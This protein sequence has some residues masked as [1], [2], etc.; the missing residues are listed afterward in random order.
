MSLWTHKTSDPDGSQV[1]GSMQLHYFVWMSAAVCAFAHTETHFRWVV[2]RV[3]IRAVR[4]YAHRYCMTQVQVQRETEGERNMTEVKR[5]E[6]SLGCEQEQPL[7][8]E[9]VP[10]GRQRGEEEEALVQVQ[11]ASQHWY[12]NNT[13]GFVCASVC[14]Y[15]VCAW[16]RERESYLVDG[17]VWLPCARGRMELRG[18]DWLC[19]LIGC[20]Q[21]VNDCSCL[22]RC[23]VLGT[24]SEEGWGVWDCVCGGE[25]IGA[26]ER[27]QERKRERGGRR[28]EREKENRSLWRE[29]GRELQAARLDY[30]SNTAV[31][32]L[33]LWGS[34]LSLLA[35]CLSFLLLLLL[36]LG[37]DPGGHLDL[38][39]H[40]EKRR[41]N[42]VAE[43]GD[44]RRGQPHTLLLW[45]ESGN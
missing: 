27:R 34:C 31:F 21:N 19:T 23:Q 5:E 12:V 25:S 6:S 39:A 15:I 9:W 42:A 20:G 10:G 13:P 17:R 3:K 37:H 24:V 14:T 40:L 32:L 30:R 26:C 38:L 43:E 33:L 1:V 16:E 41:E 35:A 7:H 29:G 2:C 11:Q 36:L 18:T 45:W 8:V 22:S 28:T 44:E 4:G